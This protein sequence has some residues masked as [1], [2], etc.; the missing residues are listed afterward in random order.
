LEGSEIE[1]IAG[2]GWCFALEVGEVEGQEGADLWC[3]K[4]VVF[5][6]HDDNADLNVGCIE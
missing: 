5:D 4:V 3:R 2:F 1:D 6:E